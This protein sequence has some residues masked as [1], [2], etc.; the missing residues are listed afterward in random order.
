MKKRTKADSTTSTTRTT[1]TSDAS[2]SSLTEAITT[3]IV[4]VLKAQY[5]QDTDSHTV[6]EQ[7]VGVV[8]T[9]CSFSL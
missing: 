3:K 9:A 4:S 2:T 8:L 6:N 1:P 5:R 7:A